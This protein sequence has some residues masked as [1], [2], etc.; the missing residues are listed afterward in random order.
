MS[1]FIYVNLQLRIE[2]GDHER[3]LRYLKDGKQ[4]HDIFI[5]KVKSETTRRK[6]ANHLERKTH[7][8]S[9]YEEE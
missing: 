1:V 9:G 5:E 3:S 8:A 7:K 6:K 2:K 4:Q